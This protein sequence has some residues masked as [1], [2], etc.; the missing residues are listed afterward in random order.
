M[1]ISSHKRVLGTIAAGLALSAAIASPAAQAAETGT[2]AT[3]TVNGGSLAVSAPAA[4]TLSSGVSIGTASVSASLGAVTV[5]DARSVIGGSWT[6]TVSST[7]FTTG[8][9]S[10]GK[11]ID[12]ANAAYTTGLASLVSG[13]AVVLTPA[14]G[15]SLDSAQ[16]AASATA[17]LG[18]SEV[19]WNPTVAVTIP[20]DVA[21]GTYTGTLTHSVA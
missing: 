17:V 21:A 15:A 8:D 10:A 13:A 1:K 11:V 16:T 4:S 5:S 12:N 2:T 14:V 19:S 6:A 20:D 9:G 18:D 7:N 3:F